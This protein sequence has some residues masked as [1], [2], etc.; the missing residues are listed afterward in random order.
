MIDFGYDYTISP[1][2]VASA[3]FTDRRLIS[4]IEDIGYVSPNGEVYNIGNPGYGIVANPANWLAWMGPG[5]PTTPKAKRDYDAIEFRLDKRFARNYQFSASYT[6]SRLY[7][8]YSG[9]AS[10]DE[11]GRDNPN[12]SRYFDQPWTVSY[13]HLTLPTNRTV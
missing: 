10:S 4:T 2:M 5:I 8:N 13:T 7:G 6:W 9:L 1:T 11:G 3:R 12:N